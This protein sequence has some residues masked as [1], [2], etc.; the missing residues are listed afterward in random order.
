[1]IKTLTT[2]KTSKGVGV[3]LK[4]TNYYLGYISERSGQILKWLWR[5]FAQYSWPCC[6]FQR[7]FSKFCVNGRHISELHKSPAKNL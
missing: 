3:N 2:Q 1:M 6:H 4:Q 5:T 7:D